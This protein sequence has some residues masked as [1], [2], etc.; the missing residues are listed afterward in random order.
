MQFSL[1][2]FHH[3]FDFVQMEEAEKYPTT[4]TVSTG[5]TLSQPNG[6]LASPGGLGKATHFD[7]PSKLYLQAS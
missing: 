3:C 6:S 5:Y 1:W 4:S 7:K 2:R